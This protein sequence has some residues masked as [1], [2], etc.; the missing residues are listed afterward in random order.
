MS[1]QLRVVDPRHIAFEM[2]PDLRTIR[3]LG[4]AVYAAAHVISLE[5]PVRTVFEQLGLM[6]HDKA[7]ELEEQRCLAAKGQR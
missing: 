7:G 4:Y 5:D 1:R 2:E 6:I 3:D